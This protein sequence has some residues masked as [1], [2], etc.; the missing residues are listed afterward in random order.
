[1]GDEYRITGL[2]CGGKVYDKN[3]RPRACLVFAEDVHYTPLSDYISQDLVAAI[4]E[5][6][7][8]GYQ[9]KQVVCSGYHASSREDPVVPALLTKLIRFCKEERYQLIYGC[10]AN[11]HN[12]LWGSKGVDRRGEE[13]VDF[14]TEHELEIT[15]TGNVPTYFVTRNVNNR[16][17]VWSDVIDLTLVTNFINQR[18]TDWW[19][20]TDTSCSDH[21][22]IEFSIKADSPKLHKYRNPK[23]TDWE[24]YSNLVRKRIGKVNLAITSTRQLDKRV[25]QFS[26]IIKGCYFESNQEKNITTNRYNSW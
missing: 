8:D 5:L 9:L 2:N 11:A 6:H 1:M 3:N 12:Q 20:S 18:I 13:L 19:V 14:I 21:R 7:S 22:Y 4:V 15:N 24:K 23:H 16:I 26:S 25:E 17:E 10:D